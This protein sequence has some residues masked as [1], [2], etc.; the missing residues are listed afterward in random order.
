METDGGEM[1][2]VM[3]GLN[4]IIILLIK[5]KLSQNYAVKKSSYNFF[6]SRSRWLH[7][8][9][10][11]YTRQKMQLFKNLLTYLT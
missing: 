5:W 9:V 7:Y 3:A 4:N 6:L 11:K 10:K 2:M 8:F 1:E